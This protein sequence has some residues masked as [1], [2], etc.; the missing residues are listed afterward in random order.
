VAPSHGQMPQTPPAPQSVS[1]A[2]LGCGGKAQS[3]PHVGTSGERHG[4]PPSTQ[5]CWSLQCPDVIPP[6]ELVVEVVEVVV[7][8]VVAVVVVLL[9]VV[10]VVVAPP[11]PLA[12]E[13]FATVPPQP[14]VRQP[15]L[16]NPRKSMFMRRMMASRR[17]PGEPK[18]R[19]S[20]GRR[21]FNDWRDRG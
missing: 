1:T 11:A 13:D 18:Q 8:V 3:P 15:R 6:L 9:L 12:P 5:G 21:A 16:S 19:V 2:Q 20:G 17:R 4:G 10:A 14:A 7:A